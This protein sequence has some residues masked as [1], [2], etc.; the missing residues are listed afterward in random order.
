VDAEINVLQL[1][2]GKDPDEVIIHT[3]AVWSYAVS[4][5]L[6]L[7]DHYF[8]VKTADL[9]LKEPG[10]K[11]EAVKR[12]LPIISMIPNRTKQDEY[13]QKLAQMGSVNE[14]SL[15]RDL[16]DILRERLTT[17]TVAKFSEASGQQHS[18]KENGGKLA[19]T[20]T[21]SPDW[22]GNAEGE[23]GDLHGKQRQVQ[24]L[25]KRKADKVQWEDYLIGLL[26]QNSGLCLHVC[27][28]INHGDFAGTDT[29]ELYHILNSIYQRGSTSLH[30][31][32]EQLVPSALLT[33][34][35]RARKSVESR[36]PLDGAGQIKAAVQCANR[37]KR[38]QMLQSNTELQYLL[39]EEK[40]VAASQQ[41]R[42]Q[43]LA[44]HQQLRTIDSATHLQ[45]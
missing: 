32:L 33:T 36:S 1:P 14:V 8:K 29:R 37:L 4:H 3:P 39:R 18:G 44:V 9:N 2:E 34:M 43:L 38:K 21:G 24:G 27:G 31:P 10:D 28:I 11:A 22:I 25:D 5:P 20:G 13:L 30:E 12:L 15:R 26:L 40:D 19:L 6:P 7:I 41:L 42:L 35:A 17:G 45:G 16:Q 23:A